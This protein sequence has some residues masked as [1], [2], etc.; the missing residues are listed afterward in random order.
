MKRHRCQGVWTIVRFNWHFFVLA[1]LG[2]VALL[3]ASTFLAPLP[4]FLAHIAALSAA[5]SIFVSLAASYLAY[6]ASGLYELKWLAPWM[7]ADGDAANIH[8]GFDETSPLLKTHHP[9]LR[10]HVLDFYDPK[11]HTEISIRRA[12]AVHPPQPGTRA[13]ST[14][15]LPLSDGSLD[16]VLLLLAAHEI[17]DHDE[18]VRFFHE[19]RRSLRPDG[20]VIVTEH[21]RDP[22]NLV[23]Y[24]I[25]AWHFHTPTEWIATFAEAGLVVVA[26]EKTNRFIT[27]FVLRPA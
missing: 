20:L 6:D 14:D 27:T 18:R 24:T 9:G 13:F 12:R 22:A 8:A 19:L 16:R 25:G 2:V 7:P 3:A 11:K 1:G 10:W 17:R 5:V 21:L 23:A 26:R 4:A 15:A